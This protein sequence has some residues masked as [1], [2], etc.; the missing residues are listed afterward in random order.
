MGGKGAG[1]VLVRAMWS[2]GLGYVVA[3]VRILG[4][5]KGGNTEVLRQEAR[6]QERVRDC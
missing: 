5:E 1:M 6:W 4:F 2:K 3:W